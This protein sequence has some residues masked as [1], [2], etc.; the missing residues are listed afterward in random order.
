MHFFC[1]LY[2]EMR[3][4]CPDVNDVKENLIT[5]LRTL[6]RSQN[7]GTITVIFEPNLR[8]LAEFL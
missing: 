2:A 8:K 3:V 1:D 6:E 7:A 4:F 5:S